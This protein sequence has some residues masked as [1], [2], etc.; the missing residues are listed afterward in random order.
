[1]RNPIAARV[2][3]LAMV[4]TGCGGTAA[5]AKE[6]G[7][8]PVASSS[9]GQLDVAAAR[10]W[11]V[12]PSNGDTVHSPVNVVMGAEGLTV[13]PAGVVH[14]GAGHFHVMVD[15]GCVQVGQKIAVDANHIHF[16]RAQTSAEIPLG[17]GKHSLCLQA[18]DGVHKALDLRDMITVTVTP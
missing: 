14:P 13:E 18:G 10:V 12:R 17:P 9:A 11:F 7:A 3:V 1:M 5:T 15:V 4:A 16:G 2:I 8:G 6:A